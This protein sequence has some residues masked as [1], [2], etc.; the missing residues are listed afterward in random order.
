MRTLETATALIYVIYFLILLAPSHRRGRWH[1]WIGIAAAIVAAAQ[2]AI[3]GY[4]WQMLPLDVVI[5]ITAILSLALLGI[6]PQPLKV[7]GIL[8]AFGAAAL[9]AIEPDAEAP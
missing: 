9:L 4:R 2:V 1:A 6:V 3:E 7:V 8:L 5:A